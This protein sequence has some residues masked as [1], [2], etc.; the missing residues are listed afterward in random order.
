MSNRSFAAA[1]RR[2][3]AFVM[4]GLPAAASAHAFL[5]SSVPAVG[6]TVRTAPAEV[7]IDFTEGVEPAFTT[8][9]VAN[10]QGQRVDRGAGHLEGDDTHFAVPLK[11]LPPGVYRVTWKAVATDTHHTQGSFTFTVAP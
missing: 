6:G 10:A 11:T 1:S 5:Q 9:E 3:L 7:R 8:M 2:A 4:I